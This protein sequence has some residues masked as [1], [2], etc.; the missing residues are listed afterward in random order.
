LPLMITPKWILSRC[1]PIAIRNVLQYLSGVLG[2]RKSFNE[3][4]DIGGPDILTYKEML[5][6]FAKVRGLKRFII[7]VP[8]LSS[9][10]SAYWVYLVTSTSFYLAKNLIE[11][12]KVEVVAKDNRIQNLVPTDLISYTDAVKLAF[13]KIEQ[14]QV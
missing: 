2:N 4:Y 12:L 11:S 3:V 13:Q 7:S 1:Q 6:R 8:F 5:I 9:K 10:L 14:N